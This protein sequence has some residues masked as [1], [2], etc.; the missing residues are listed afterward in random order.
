MTALERYAVRAAELHD[1]P[2][3]LERLTDCTRRARGIWASVD[4][5]D[6]CGGD[7]DVAD[8]A[9]YLYG[10]PEWAA[11]SSEENRAT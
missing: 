4:C 1:D 10:D 2:A 3:G 8:L 9:L 7:E 5:P 6:G 11:A